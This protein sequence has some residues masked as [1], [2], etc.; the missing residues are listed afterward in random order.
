MDSYRQIRPHIAEYNVPD[1][2]IRIPTSALSR[3]PPYPARPPVRAFGQT[4]SKSVGLPTELL[5]Q[6]TE[7]VGFLTELTCAPY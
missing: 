4:D 7:S 1:H 2:K 5:I 6:C 3:R